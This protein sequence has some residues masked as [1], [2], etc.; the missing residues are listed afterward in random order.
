M[1]SCNGLE[2]LPEWLLPSLKQLR[3][4][5]LESCFHLA[6]LPGSLTSLAK[7]EHLNLGLCFALKTLPP[8]MTALASLKVLDMTSNGVPVA[9]IPCLGEGVEILGDA[10]PFSTVYTL[11]PK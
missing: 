7:L 3:K 6:S 8:G 2:R 11:K 1:G 9:S 4:L 5:N 10:L